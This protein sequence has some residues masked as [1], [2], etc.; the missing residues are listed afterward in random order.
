MEAFEYLKKQIPNICETD[1]LLW[2]NPDYS[3]A[4]WRNVMDICSGM[5]K[6]AVNVIALCGP[7]EN[8]L[9]NDEYIR[10]KCFDMCFEH[11]IL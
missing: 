7:E 10:E 1:N 11:I 6:F 4:V 8:K 3:K 5:E 9:Y 2:R